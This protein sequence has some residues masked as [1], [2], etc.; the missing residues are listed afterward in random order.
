TVMDT[1]GVALAE[2]GRLE[3]ARSTFVAALAKDPANAAVLLHMGM[4]S[5]RQKDAA[6]ARS[7]FEKSLASQPKAPGTLSALGLA[8]VELRDEAGA[9]ES[10]SRAVEL[11]PGQYDT[12]FNLAV[13][14]GRMGKKEAARHA[15][16]QF[17]RTAPP[18]R[19]ASRLDEARRLLRS[20]DHPTG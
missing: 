8:Q 16:E 19:Y 5:L 2:A 13:L 7:W 20:L 6:A 4:L 17:L 11:D 9:F 3:E 12:L 14:A 18:A 15:L 10:W 1:R